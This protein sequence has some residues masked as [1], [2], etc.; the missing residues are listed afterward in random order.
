MLGTNDLK[1]EFNRTSQDIAQGI[2]E[3][4]EIIQQSKYGHNMQSPPKILIISPPVPTTENFFED[5]FMNAI[6]R[7]KECAYE[8][9][10]VADQQN[11]YF[12]D[13]APHV[14]FSEIDGIHFDE[15]AHQDFA[16]V[17]HT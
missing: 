9:K 14:R 8:Y 7:G 2:R 11:C 1:K 17:L 10:K 15:K 16:K 12:L 6:P 13:A 5:M 3:L 4:I